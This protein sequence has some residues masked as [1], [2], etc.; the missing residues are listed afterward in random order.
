MCVGIETCLWFWDYRD[1]KNRGSNEF[2][3]HEYVILL[4]STYWL[5]LTFET[6]ADKSAIHLAQISNMGL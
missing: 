2:L 6:Y 1:K 5:F 3:L 4:L